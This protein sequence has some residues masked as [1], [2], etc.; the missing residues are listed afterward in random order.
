V[1]IQ[2]EKTSKQLGKVVK[3]VLQMNPQQPFYQ[4][5]MNA[6]EELL[7]SSYQDILI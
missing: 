5:M 3:K 7:F 4:P 6:S 2:V 1:K